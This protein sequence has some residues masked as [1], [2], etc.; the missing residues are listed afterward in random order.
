MQRGCA[1]ENVFLD[2]TKILKQTSAKIVNPRVQ[3]VQ[4]NSNVNP[5]LRII[6]LQIKIALH[7][8]LLAIS[9]MLIKILV[10]FATQNA[11]INVLALML[12][13][14]YLVNSETIF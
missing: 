14:V 10:L 13:N 4:T 11:G 12:S 5:V 2:N 3:T 8:V 7:R 9:K 1:Q 6:I